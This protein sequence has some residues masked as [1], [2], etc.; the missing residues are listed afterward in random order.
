MTR[1]VKLGRLT[2]EL[3]PLDYPV[4]REAATDA[5]DE[6][7]LQYA[8]GEEPLPAV[9]DRSSEDTFESRDDLETEL[10]GLHPTEAVGE[11]GQ[12]EGEG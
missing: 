6:V 10:Y 4:S 2:T 12:S 11:P 3:D 5:L 8:D 9:L 7:V 1:R